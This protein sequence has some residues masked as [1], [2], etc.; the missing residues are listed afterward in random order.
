MNRT[1]K[2]NSI[3]MKKLINFEIIEEDKSI[4]I[5]NII[6]K[7]K[8]SEFIPNNLI[9]KILNYYFP[10]HTLLHNYSSNHLIIKVKLN[11]LLNAPV[12]NWE[13]NRPPD[14]TR[15]QEIS[16]YLYNNKEKPIDT[17][18][19]I[20]YN[21]NNNTLDMLDGIHRFSSLKLL[22]DE[23]NKGL[24]LLTGSCEAS[25]FINENCNEWFYNKDLII[26]IRFN[27][28][29]EQQMDLFRT[30]NKSQPV[31]NLYIRDSSLEKRKVIEE[32]ANEWQVNYPKHFSSSS[33]PNMGNTNR[34]KFI[35]LLDFIYKK[36]KINESK[37][38]YFRQILEDLN[39]N[40]STN[41]PKKVPSTTKKRCDSSGCYLF[42]Y[43]NE[44][45]E[46]MI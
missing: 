12:L 32:I 43:K 22:K 26:N 19:Y 13:Y 27:Y 41:M 7:Y 11:D 37:I 28:T 10:S 45:L 15:C 3:N 35:E 40:I 6:N 44:V 8:D 1:N 20:C 14:M 24:D 4:E 9:P 34:D 23:M 25:E 30:L 21:N 46:T 33:N 42:L 16:R 2:I 31:P 36:Y 18:F 29:Q 39:I 17:M 5:E 38:N